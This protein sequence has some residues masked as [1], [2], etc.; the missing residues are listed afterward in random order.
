MNIDAFWALLEPIKDA[1]EPEIEIAKVLK[2]LE[3]SEIE[4]YQAHF[5]Q[6]EQQI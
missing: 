5:D 4:A 2:T 1:E 3:A 6:W